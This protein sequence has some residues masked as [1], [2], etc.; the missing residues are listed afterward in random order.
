MNP[1]KGLVGYYNYTVIITYISL[2]LAVIGLVNA[3][4]GNVHAAII[5]LLAC[6][7]CDAFDGTIAKT[8]K[9]TAQEKS[10]GAHI[11]SLSDL[12][13][14][15]ILPATILFG[16]G[17]RGPLCYVAMIFYALTALIRL[18][19]FD[20]QEIYSNR[21]VERREYFSGLPVTNAAVVFPTALVLD[22]LFK[23]DAKYFYLAF[24]ILT[25]IAFVTP[26]KIK[27]LYLPALLIPVGI[28]FV[29]GIVFIIFGGVYNA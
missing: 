17:L 11:D 27:K 5:C 20:V 1:K 25:G 2:G 26:L 3:T 18:A 19:Y 4:S 14:F 7:L 29:V 24:L 28:V 22:L 16:L 23:I 12:V 13:A 15:G 8:K 9:R 10:F 6:G 21:D